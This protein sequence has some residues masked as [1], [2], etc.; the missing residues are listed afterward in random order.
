MIAFTVALWKSN[1]VVVI[2]GVG[3]RV[4]FKESEINQ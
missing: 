3:A 4:K 1:M 2:E